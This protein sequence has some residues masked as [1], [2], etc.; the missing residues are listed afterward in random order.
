MSNFGNTQRMM[1]HAMRSVS[2][3][4]NPNE[5][6]QNNT[7]REATC[8]ISTDSTF[9]E[10]ISNDPVS[11]NRVA[12]AD[13]PSQLPI[14]YEHIE[15]N[16]GEN[17]STIELSTPRDVAPH[18]ADETRAH[19]NRL[20]ERDER[21]DQEEPNSEIEVE[22]SQ[23]SSATNSFD[24]EF[25]PGVR[26]SDRL[27][28]VRDIEHLYFFRNRTAVGKVYICRNRK[29]C[30][31]KV[32]IDWDGLCKQHGTAPHSHA[33]VGADYRNI[34]FKREVKEECTNSNILHKES[35]RK[36]FDAKLAA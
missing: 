29:D 21:N 13:E 10:N 9:E 12:A 22:N 26:E 33:S 20:N 7:N 24:Y 36:V 32:I 30:E 18:T 23:P 25:I 31:A 6:L 15:I 16:P 35:V 34:K 11:L 3:D 19:Q 27:L 8:A 14:I 17:S 2:L 5:Q 28:Y 4:A 1:K